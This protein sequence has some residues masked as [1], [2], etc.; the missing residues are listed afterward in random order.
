MRFLF[1]SDIELGTLDWRPNSSAGRSSQKVTITAAL[2]TRAA[3]ACEAE[4][5]LCFEVVGT[6][7]RSFV[8]VTTP[9]CD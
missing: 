7:G 9:E 1:P 8:P 3:A 2:A 6:A 4:D 5:I